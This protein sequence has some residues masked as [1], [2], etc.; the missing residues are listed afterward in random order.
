[1]LDKLSQETDDSTPPCKNCNEVEKGILNKECLK[2][3][4]QE[5]LSIDKI[6]DLFFESGASPYTVVEDFGSGLGKYHESFLLRVI[7]LIS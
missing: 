6:Y 3:K 4:L 7:S 2:V 5:W 1:M